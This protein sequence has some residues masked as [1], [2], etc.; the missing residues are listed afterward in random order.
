MDRV[1]AELETGQHAIL[2]GL[3]A[4]GEPQGHER[5]PAAVQQP[6]RGAGICF[7]S[8][9]NRRSDA[10][11]TSLTAAGEVLLS[12]FTRSPMPATCPVK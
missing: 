1:L 12:A 5:V 4:A 3:R 11:A 8:S 10:A 9:P 7:N 6:G 2:S